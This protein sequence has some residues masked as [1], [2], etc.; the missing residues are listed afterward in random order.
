M[1][2]VEQA[3]LDHSWSALAEGGEHGPCGWLKD[4]F[5]LS[6]QV[7]P[8]AITGWMASTDTV[9]RDRAFKA[10]LEMQKLD[11]SFEGR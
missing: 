11:I 9:A 4:C 5:G 3:E 1:A 6:W 7:A 2:A 8:T 10:M